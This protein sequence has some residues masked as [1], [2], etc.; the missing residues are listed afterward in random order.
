MSRRTLVAYKEEQSDLSR[1]RSGSKNTDR[2]GVDARLPLRR[3]GGGDG[4]GGG[5]TKRGVG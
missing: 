4:G 1:L 5:R 3:S 2:I